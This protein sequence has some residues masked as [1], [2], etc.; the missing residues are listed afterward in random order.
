MCFESCPSFPFWNLTF[1][2]VPPFFCR[3]ISSFQ[4][5]HSHQMLNMPNSQQFRR[6][7]PHLQSTN[8]QSSFH[9][10]L[11]ISFVSYLYYCLYFFASYSSN[12]LSLA[13][14][15]KQLC[16]KSPKTSMLIQW[17]D[18]NRFRCQLPS[19]YPETFSSLVFCDT[20]VSR[21]S[22]SFLTIFLRLHL[23]T[24]SFL[25]GH[26][27]KVSE[28]SFPLLFSIYII[29]QC[30]FIHMHDFK[31]HPYSY[32]DQTSLLSSGLCESSL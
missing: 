6:K 7:Y 32:D 13:P 4:M 11:S 16:L 26:L 19:L 18:L 20:I 15:S 25:P 24:Q 21:F 29:S 10:Y 8:I 2:I 5:N 1:W 31:C 22:R 17:L 30:E 3:F 14:T 9:P 27:T 12:Y 23:K 28:A